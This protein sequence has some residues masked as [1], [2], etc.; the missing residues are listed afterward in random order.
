M[1]KS[2]VSVSIELITTNQEEFTMNSDLSLALALVSVAFCPV[3]CGLM[4]Y[5]VSRTYL[6]LRNA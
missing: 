6:A 1:L 2:L 3:L 5:R 4:A